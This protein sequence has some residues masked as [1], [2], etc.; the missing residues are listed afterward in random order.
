MAEKC[1]ALTIAGQ[2]EAALT[3]VGSINARIAQVRG[4]M[5][6]RFGGSRSRE[7]IHELNV[8]ERSAEQAAEILNQSTKKFVAVVDLTESM[9][10][11]ERR[12]VGTAL[13][14]GY[15]LF[16]VGMMAACGFGDGDATSNWL[17]PIDLK[18]A[19]QAA[20]ISINGGGQGYE[21]SI[22]ATHSYLEQLG[23]L[24]VGASGLSDLGPGYTDV[25]LMTD[26][27]SGGRINFPSESV[28][29]PDALRELESYLGRRHAMG[30]SHVDLN[31]MPLLEDLRN[32]KVRLHPITPRANTDTYRYYDNI[33]HLGLYWQAIANM[34]GGGW[35]ELGKPVNFDQFG[36]KQQNVQT[37]SGMAGAG[38]AINQA[39]T[40]AAMRNVRL[41]QD[42][43][44]L[45][46]AN[47]STAVRR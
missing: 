3:S 36:A 10:G 18:N 2:R 27:L 43:L 47:S 38:N 31:L 29:T 33:K 11:E 35:Q 15:A 23:L 8:L 21:S 7:A 28:M 5:D 13:E 16:G 37:V 44:A 1:V 9:S 41:Y 39:T 25:I 26:E 30:R 34:T 4:A 22:E 19:Q 46:G 17:M 40:A 32:A 45:P 20:M 14:T 42:V 6:P 24:A 12:A